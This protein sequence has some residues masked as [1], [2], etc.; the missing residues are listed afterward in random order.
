MIKLVHFFSCQALIEDQKIG[1]IKYFEARGYEKFLFRI[2][3]SIKY[4]ISASQKTHQQIAE[5]TEIYI[6][7]NL[8]KVVFKN[9]LQDWLLFDIKNTTKFDAAMSSG[10][11]LI[12][13]SGSKFLGNAKVEKKLY[14]VREIFL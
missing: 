10:Y 2:P 5:Q 3:N 13:A 11:T 7:E 8:H 6:N 14:D 9:L 1:L 12:A 4:G